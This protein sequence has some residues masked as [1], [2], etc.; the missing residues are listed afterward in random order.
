MRLFLSALIFFGPC[1][2][3]VAQSLENFEGESAA[4]YAQIVQLF[5]GMR[6]GDSTKVHAVFHSDV[7]LLTTF[8]N[9]AGEPVLHEG[10]LQGFLEAVGSPHDEIWDE[11]IWETAIQVDGPLAQAWTN[12]AFYLGDTFSHCGVDAFQLVKT[13]EG[14]KIIQLADTRRKTDCRPAEELIREQVEAFSKSV[15]AGDAAA[16]AAAYTADAKI[17]PGNQTILH[18]QEAIQEYWTPAGSSRTVYHK[19][20]PEEIVVKGDLAYDWGYYEGRSRKADGTEVDWKGKYVIVW[21]LE[22]GIWKIYLD[23]WNRLPA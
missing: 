5:D 11:R 19:V 20:L 21:K 8:L 7:L 15:V 4:V 3:L 13:A 17:F 16:V 14:W 10:S 6:E 9:R 23:I 1:S 12:Y 18:G 22:A 2:L